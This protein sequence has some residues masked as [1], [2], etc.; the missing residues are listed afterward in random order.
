[1][2][3]AGSYGSFHGSPLSLSDLSHEYGLPLGGKAED[4]RRLEDAKPIALAPIQVY[5]HLHETGQ[6]AGRLVIA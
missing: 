6:V 5:R 4:R 3:G 2:G 1:M